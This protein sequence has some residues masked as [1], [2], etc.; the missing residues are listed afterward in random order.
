MIIIET[1][2][3]VKITLIQMVLDT[4]QSQDASLNRI[5]DSYLK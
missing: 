4:Q 1:R 2:L 3:E 5:W